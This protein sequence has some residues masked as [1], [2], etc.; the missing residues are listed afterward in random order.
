MRK[1]KPA[2][3]LSTL[4]KVSQSEEGMAKPYQGSGEA[5]NFV[6]FLT[7]QQGYPAPCPTPAEQPVAPPRCPWGP[8]HIWG[9]CAAAH[10][11]PVEGACAVQDCAS[12]SQT[13]RRSFIKGGGT[14]LITPANFTPLCSVSEFPEAGAADPSSCPANLRPKQRWTLHP[15]LLIILIII[16]KITSK[17]CT[18]SPTDDL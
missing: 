4:L 12:P 17:P 1:R 14:G 13:L 15:V 3:T 8:I 11:C 16:W 6:K 10:V 9:L 2:S 18:S 7:V 5:Q